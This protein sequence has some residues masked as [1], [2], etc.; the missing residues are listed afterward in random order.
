[1]SEQQL[2][3]RSLV[4]SYLTQHGWEDLIG[5]SFDEGQWFDVEASLEYHSS[6]ANLSVDYRAETHELVF[7]LLDHEGQG[8]QFIIDYKENLIGVIETIVGFQEDISNIDFKTYISKLLRVCDVYLY[9]DGQLFQ[10]TDDG[11][12]AQSK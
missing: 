6:R 4:I 7:T 5:S 11:A 9:V 2:K 10:L 12:D 3:E 8:Q 1:M